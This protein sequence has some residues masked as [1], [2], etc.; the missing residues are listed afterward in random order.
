MLH[1]AEHWRERLIA[2]DA[3]LAVWLEQ[4]PESDAQQLRALIRQARKDAP[5]ADRDQQSR[6][7][8]PRQSRAF[9]E[10]FQLVREQLGTTAA[11][12]ADQP[13]DAQ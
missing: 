3:A 2:D 5:P 13:A 7:L 10:L 11:A 4:H 9:R 6:G 8:A 1:G 12:A